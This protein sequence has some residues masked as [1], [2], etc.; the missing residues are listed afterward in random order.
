[1]GLL[2]RAYHAVLRKTF[3]LASSGHSSP[4]EQRVG[5]EYRTGAAT[6]TFCALST[7]DPHHLILI[8]EIGEF[9]WQEYFFKLAS[10]DAPQTRDGFLAWVR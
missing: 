1:M 7:Q 5:H 6:R 8:P 10:G 9:E 4:A 3:R 2:P